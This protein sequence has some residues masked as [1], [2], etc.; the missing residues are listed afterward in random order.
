MNAS[1]RHFRVLLLGAILA[2]AR[3][4]ALAADLV[5]HE[6]GTITTIHAADGT[7][8]TGLNRI[9]EADVLP[10]VR[11]SLRAGNHA[12]QAG[13]HARQVAQHSGSART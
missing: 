10:D 7:P 9:D 12:A 1:G 11:A 4:P 5:V 8:A 2:G 6:W 13:A 3:S